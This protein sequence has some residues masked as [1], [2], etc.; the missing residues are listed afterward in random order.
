MTFVFN[1]SKGARKRVVRSFGAGQYLTDE[2]IQCVFAAC[3]NVPSDVELLSPAVA[4]CMS[5]GDAAENAP[6]T[7]GKKLIVAPINNSPDGSAD[8]GTHWTLLLGVREA[9]ANIIW[10]HLNSAT[11]RGG[12]GANY[13]RAKKAAEMLTGRKAMVEK[14]PCSQQTNGYDCGVYVLMF[15]LIA[16]RALSNVDVAGALRRECVM[17]SSLMV[18][19][20]FAEIFASQCLGGPGPAQLHGLTFKWLSK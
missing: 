13:A 12:G 20:P 9:S 14:V 1:I 2:C 19:T 7:Q 4:Y 6:D 11:P 18:R 17:P 3:P 5:I 16:L 15:T 10:M 8:S